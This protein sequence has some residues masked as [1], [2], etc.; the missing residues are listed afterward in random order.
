MK[1]QESRSCMT[2]SAQY[3]V[4]SDGGFSVEGLGCRV[5]GLGLRV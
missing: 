1:L 2:Q 4:I 3:P 5:K